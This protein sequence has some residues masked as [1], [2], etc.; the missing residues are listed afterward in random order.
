MPAVAA[1]TD[2]PY[3]KA[4]LGA[5][6]V[7][8]M[9]DGIIASALLPAGIILI[10][11]ASAR[12]EFSV[13]GVVLVGLGGL[14][15]LAYSFGRDMFA[16]AGWGKRLMGLTV[17]STSTGMVAKAGSTILRQ[18]VLYALGII[19]V[20]G[21][22][23]EPVM[24]LVDK[25]GKRVGDKVAKTQV[26]RSTD[27]A[28]RGVAVSTGKGA[29]I[30]ALVAALLVSI[31]GGVAG[32]LVFARTVSGAMDA[33]ADLSPVVPEIEVPTEQPTEQ[34]PA[35][36]PTEQPPAEQPS[37]EQPGEPGDGAAVVGAVNP[38]TS[39]D[40]V[41]NLLN[42][43]KENNVEAARQ[44]ATR[45]FQ[46]DESWFFA[47]AGGALAQFEVTDVYQDQAVWVVE[48]SEDWNSGP[49]KSRY[50][51]IEEDNTARV[52]GVEFLD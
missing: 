49:Q 32:G 18:V 1:P 2:A 29:A 33:G 12:E 37:T 6:F 8:V 11:A 7:A 48:V 20:I 25:E 46:E 39:V 52:D 13:V 21:S 14:W 15:Q 23:I 45:R 34:P 35:E 40:A 44:Y 4:P 17:V 43:L 36:Q 28:A 50:F 10:A 5:R 30:G 41:G 47:P 22:L 42:Y 51:V 26:V 16:G 19:P 27:A 31:V 9:V 3:D 38:E 24:V